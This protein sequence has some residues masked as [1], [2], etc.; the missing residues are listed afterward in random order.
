MRALA[1]WGLAKTAVTAQRET[2]DRFKKADAGNFLV[3]EF[4]LT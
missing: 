4:F 2:A 1:D 3:I